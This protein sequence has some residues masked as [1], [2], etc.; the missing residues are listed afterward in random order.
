MSSGFWRNMEIKEEL[1]KRLYE[2]RKQL[3]MTQDEVA[4]AIGVAQPVYQR[5]EK[6]IYECNYAQLCAICKT[7][8]LSADFLLG[9]E[10]YWKQLRWFYAGL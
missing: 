1:G 7:L 5:F 2:R 6:G 10:Q 4:K 3:N 9:L 8:D